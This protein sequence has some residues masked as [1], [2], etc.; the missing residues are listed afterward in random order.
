MS[1]CCVS[2]GR[3]VFCIV[4]CRVVVLSCCCVVVLL[5]CR[6]VVLSCCRVVVCC[7][8]IESVSQSSEAKNIK[9]SSLCLCLSHHTPAVYKFIGY[10]YICDRDASRVQYIYS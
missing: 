9:A 5:C 2:K 3:V 1:V 7:R 10:Y 4:F 8:R 6:V